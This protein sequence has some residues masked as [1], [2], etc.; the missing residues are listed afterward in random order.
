MCLYTQDSFARP[1]RRLPR[2]RL[3]LTV[4]ISQISQRFPFAGRP[5]R[6]SPPRN[7][8][9]TSRA[10][11]AGARRRR[12]TSAI[13]V[14]SR[15]SDVACAAFLTFKGVRQTIDAFQ[16]SLVDIQMRI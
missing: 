14:R 8:G 10:V 5:V 9:N 1:Y 16:D 6:L 15:V 7:R 3:N 13:R 2:A 11:N 4:E 12:E